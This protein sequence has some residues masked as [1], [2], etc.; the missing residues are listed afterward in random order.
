MSTFRGVAVALAAGMAALGSAALVLT[1]ATAAT[2]TPA[3]APGRS[4]VVVQPA[5]PKDLKTVGPY[6]NSFLGYIEGRAGV[7][8]ASFKAFYFADLVKGEKAL[9]EKKPGFAMPTVGLYLKHRAALAMHA[10]V[11]IE[12]E[13]KLD[14]GYHLVGRAP[15]AA[16]TSLAPL[17]GKRV[18]WTAF[19]DP[20]FVSKVILAGT[21][22]ETFT[23]QTVLQPVAAARAVIDGTADLALLATADLGA[24]RKLPGGDKLVVVWNAPI[25]PNPPVVSLA[26]ASTADVAAVRDA[27]VGM[28]GDTAKGGKGICDEFH[29][30]GFVAATDAMY[31]AVAAKLVKP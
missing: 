8:A 21:P 24:A 20:A 6:I 19:D 22:L 18:A 7:P 1:A 10:L 9:L 2:A 27:L 17:A 31:D 5:G 14:S 26:A 30:S 23:L 13:G 3:T 25:V 11:R 4:F 15:A 28:C 12:V 16:V 29:I